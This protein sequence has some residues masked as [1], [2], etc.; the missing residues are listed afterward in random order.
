MNKAWEANPDDE[1]EDEES[2]EGIY[3]IEDMAD[4]DEGIAR[5]QAKKGRGGEDGAPKENARK[6]K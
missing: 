1:G 4:G 3:N 2:D 5:K 6:P